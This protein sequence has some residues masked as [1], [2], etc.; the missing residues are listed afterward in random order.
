MRT[1]IINYDKTK[2][3]LNKMK[4]DINCRHYNGDGY[5]YKIVNGEINLCV[6]CEAKLRVQIFEQIKI[7]KEVKD[8]FKK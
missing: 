7:E 4:I 5:T 1:Q 6:K 2:A 8:L 3:K